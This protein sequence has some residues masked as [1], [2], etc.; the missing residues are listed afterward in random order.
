FRDELAVAAGDDVTV[1]T[2]GAGKGFDDDGDL[3]SRCGHKSGKFTAVDTSADDV[4]L[5]GPTSGTTGVPKVTMHFHRDI[6]V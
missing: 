5:L 6:L 3:V 2:Y 4:A 1:L